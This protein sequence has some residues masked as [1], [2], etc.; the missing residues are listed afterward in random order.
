MIIKSSR[1]WVIFVRLFLSVER[2]KMLEA[3][4]IRFIY[5]VSSANI[6]GENT[7]SGIAFRLNEYVPV[8]L[9]LEVRLGGVI[10]EPYFRK[11]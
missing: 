5:M 2:S 4:G 10:A 7:D 6:E 9:K 11:Q 1:C 3:G 8:V